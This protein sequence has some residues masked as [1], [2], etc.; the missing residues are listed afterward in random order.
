[1]RCLALQLAAINSV[2]TG[3]VVIIVVIIIITIIVIIII[4][5]PPS[6]SY[7]W[8]DC[9]IST[10]YLS[11]YPFISTIRQTDYTLFDPSGALVFILIY[12]IHKNKHTNPQCTHFSKNFQFGAIVTIY[13]SHWFTIS[14]FLDHRI[15][16]LL[17]WLYICK[18][19]QELED[20]HLRSYHFVQRPLPVWF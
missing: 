12:Y 2:S 16:G 5:I 20:H 11:I 4:I 13:I 17:L 1:M 7:I 15:A 18:C 10:T 19:S 3:D 6:P 14:L 9:H 8:M